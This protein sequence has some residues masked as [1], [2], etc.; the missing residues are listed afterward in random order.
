M[1]KWMANIVLELSKSDGKNN[2]HTTV[3]SKLTTDYVYA[4]SWY[5]QI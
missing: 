2:H 4:T 5:G 1:M 3:C